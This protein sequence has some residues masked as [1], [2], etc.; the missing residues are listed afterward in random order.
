MPMKK[1]KKDSFSLQLSQINHI[2]ERQKL[3]IQ[4]ISP[5]KE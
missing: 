4:L 3:S 1:N 2:M 5:F